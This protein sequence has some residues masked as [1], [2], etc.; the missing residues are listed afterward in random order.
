MITVPH[1]PSDQDILEGIRNEH[2]WAY[3]Q[4]YK[5]NREGIFNYVKM[6]SGDEDEAADVLQDAVII[7][8]EKVRDN[9][10]VLTSSLKTYLT[11]ICNNLWYKRLRAKGK[12]TIVP[13]LHGYPAELL[14]ED[15]DEEEELT[16]QLMHLMDSLGESCKQLLLARFWQKKKMK[17]IAEEQGTSEAVIKN[18]SSRCIGRL[19]KAF[20]D[21]PSI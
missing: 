3:D 20:K 21:S 18:K 14:D 4:L 19:H 13:D 1:S 8:Y 5:M 12:M 15:A 9:K 16:N 17:A 10:L 11:A 7:V 6:N 2:N